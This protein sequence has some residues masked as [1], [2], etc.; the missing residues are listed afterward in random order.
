MHLIRGQ[1]VVAPGIWLTALLDLGFVAR[2][3][4]VPGAVIATGVLGICSAAPEGSD[5]E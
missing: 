4:L 1:A 5:H 2:P 3:L